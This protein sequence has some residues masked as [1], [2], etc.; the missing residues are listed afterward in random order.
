MI[1]TY[2]VKDSTTLTNKI[3]YLYNHFYDAH[4]SGALV[5]E[6]LSEIFINYGD[7]FAN[8]IKQGKVSDETIDDVNM[9]LSGFIGQNKDKY[10]TF[11]H[12]GLDRATNTVFESVNIAKNN[13][14][15]KFST[16]NQLNMTPEERES[17]SKG[18]RKLGS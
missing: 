15:K 16:Y 10:F 8:K 6:E 13:A 9:L 1:N 14:N 7:L 4:L 11:Q 3:F 12:K 17:Y 18:F 5:G 2:D